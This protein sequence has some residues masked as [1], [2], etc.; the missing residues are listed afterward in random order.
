MGAVFLYKSYGI[1]VADCM[2]A[3]SKMSIEKCFEHHEWSKKYVKTQ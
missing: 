1:P 3:Q 2:N